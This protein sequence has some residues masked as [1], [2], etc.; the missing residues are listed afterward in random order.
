MAPGDDAAAVVV[1]VGL[2][3][4]IGNFLVSLGGQLI[5]QLAGQVSRSV[6][7][8]RHFSGP[9][10]HNLQNLRAIQKLAAYYK[11]KLLIIHIH[12]NYLH[13]SAHGALVC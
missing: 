4:D 1:V 9:G 6:Q 10:S 8:I 7:L 2:F 13:F 12:E 5:N 3:D 11:P